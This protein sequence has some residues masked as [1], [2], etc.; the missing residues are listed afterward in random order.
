MPSVCRD[1]AASAPTIVSQ[2][3][4]G[5]VAVVEDD[6]GMRL[7]LQRVPETS[8]FAVELFSTAEALLAAD[9]TS[10]TLC[11]VLDIHLP[12]MSGLA[13]RQLLEA[14]GVRLPIVFI[15]ARDGAH[16][17]RQAAEGASDYLVKPFL[18]EALVAA[19]NRALRGGPG[20]G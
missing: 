13:L 12:G 18:S 7:D 15:T 19:V 6:D 10:R 11:L 8:G 5:V 4:A 16:L 17:R 2:I 3:P 9:I 20:P 14:K 1:R